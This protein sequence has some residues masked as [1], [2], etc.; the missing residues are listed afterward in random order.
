MNESIKK[1]KLW[2]LQWLW[3]SMAILIVLWIT[4]AASV[5][6]V[7]SWQ[8]LTADMW[9]SMAWNYDYSTWEV[10]TWK[11]WVDGKPIY[12]RVILFWDLSANSSNDNTWYNAP[13]NLQNP[14]TLI[15]SNSL[16]VWRSELYSIYGSYTSQMRY[17][18]DNTNFSYVFSS[19][20]SVYFTDVKVIVEYT[21]TTD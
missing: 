14:D 21:K 6:T 2:I 10:V 9:N 18:V 5:S 4:Y 15:S 1:I 17:F 13:L 7:T 11:K 3:F 16:F 20:Y 19:A 12:R 8:A